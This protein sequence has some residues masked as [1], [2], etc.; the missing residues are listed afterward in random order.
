MLMAERG[1]IFKNNLLINTQI[2]FSCVDYLLI[3]DTSKDII[4]RINVTYETFY[5][6]SFFKSPNSVSLVTPEGLA[7]TLITISLGF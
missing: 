6:V 1:H 4:L 5:K 2:L 3:K 7:G